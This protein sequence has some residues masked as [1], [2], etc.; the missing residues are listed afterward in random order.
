MRG[1][2]SGWRERRN[3]DSRN[4]NGSESFQMERRVKGEE[5]NHVKSLKFA[6]IRRDAL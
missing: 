4:R 1:G 2:R 3:E 6:S 5:L